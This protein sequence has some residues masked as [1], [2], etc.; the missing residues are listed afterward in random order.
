[1]TPPN[2]DQ[3]WVKPEGMNDDTWKIALASVKAE[4][5]KRERILNT[6]STT[7]QLMLYLVDDEYTSKKGD[8]VKT[9]KLSFTR[10][11]GDINLVLAGNKHQLKAEGNDFHR[12]ITFKANGQKVESIEELTTMINDILG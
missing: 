10:L 8:T 11:A 3:K 1:M 5:I 7:K 4:K 12:M 2:N 6:K 9:P